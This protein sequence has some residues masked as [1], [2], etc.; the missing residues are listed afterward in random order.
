MTRLL[1]DRERDT[2]ARI[3]QDAIARPI[4]RRS[5]VPRIAPQTAV[6]QPASIGDGRSAG[7]RRNDA[8]LIPC[9][10]DVGRV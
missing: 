5:D 1:G 8:T 4:E 2:I 7:T 3:S 9:R 10:A 6:R